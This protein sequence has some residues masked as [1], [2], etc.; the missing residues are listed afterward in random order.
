MRHFGLDKSRCTSLSALTFA[1]ALSWGEGAGAQS[2]VP[3]SQT[4]Q[5]PT[6]EVSPEFVDAVRRALVENPQI[7]IEV[8]TVLEAQQ[9]SQEAGKD[10]ALI[11]RHADEL[12]ADL[13]TSKPI[14]IE[15]QDYNCGYCRRS[16]PDVVAVRTATP[17]LQVVVLEFPVLGEDSIYTA[18]IA[19]AVKS[20]YGA[21]TY[22]SFVDTVMALE[23]PA[24]PATVLRI[25]DV[26]G[27]D[28]TAVT[29]ASKSSV[30]SDELER[31]A[32]LARTMGV[33]G[34]PAFVGPSGIS[35][36]AASRAHLAA[37]AQPIPTASDSSPKG[38]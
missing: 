23:S 32:Y 8:L 20:L 27:L 34:T 24:N 16:H 7:I 29:R 35:R 3:V 22:Q 15:F 6:V 30:V 9:A 28:G 4:P 36:G 37:I 19:L 33:R 21:D 11:D 17:D 31:A 1:L 26:L 12:F 13:D 10:Q 25:L 18:Q 14:L 5:V 2:V 38:E